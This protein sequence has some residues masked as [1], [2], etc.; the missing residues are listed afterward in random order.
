[1][2]THVQYILIRNFVSYPLD[3]DLV[4]LLFQ[5]L[6]SSLVNNFTQAMVCDDLGMTDY[7]IHS[8][9]RLVDK[10]TMKHKE[11]ADLLEGN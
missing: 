11:K 10:D 8:E 9:A 6:R 1:M 7:I 2:Y 3:G 5:L 4:F